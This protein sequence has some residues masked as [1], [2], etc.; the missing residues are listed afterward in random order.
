MRKKE[1]ER[2]RKGEFPSRNGERKR[3]SA[4]RGTEG[5]EEG[6]KTVA[7]GRA[8]LKCGIMTGKGEED[9]S[10]ANENFFSLQ[11]LGNDLGLVKI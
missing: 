11:K 4:E 10:P 8:R 6:R 9:L 2:A 1:G 5:R 7:R 3:K